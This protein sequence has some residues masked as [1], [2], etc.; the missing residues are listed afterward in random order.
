MQKHAEIPRAPTRTKKYRSKKTNDL[1]PLQKV[2]AQPAA[3]G[4]CFRSCLQTDTFQYSK[5]LDRY[6]SVLYIA[7]LANQ[8]WECDCAMID[9]L[10]DL[11]P[12][13]CK[14]ITLFRVTAFPCQ[15]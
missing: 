11:K 1:Q 15:M 4:L 13:R 3:N 7:V 2:A 8:I 5:G 6:F 12:A 9:V 10:F 14:G